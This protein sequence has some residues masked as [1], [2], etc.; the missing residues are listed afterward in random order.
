MMAD[1]EKA[2]EIVIG[3]EG[4]Y[5]DNPADPGGETKYGISKRAFPDLDIKNR[6]LEQ[7]KEIYLV[8][9]WAKSCCD[10][11]V[12]PLNIYL[13]DAAVNIGVGT[14]RALLAKSDFDA[15]ALLLNRIGYYCDLAN[16]KETARQFFRGW[17]NRVEKL[18][19]T[20]D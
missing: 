7:A 9:Y 8:E 18:Y 1:F 15:S 19:R 17:I 20:L 14:A 13:F 10:D 5:S 3:L 11:L 6:T 16:K 2:F 12:S 4:G